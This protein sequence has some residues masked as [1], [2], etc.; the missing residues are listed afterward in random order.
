[1]SR[2][3]IGFLSLRTNIERI[4]VK[5]ASDN[6]Y[7]QRMNWLQRWAKLYQGKFES[8]SN[9][10]CHC[11][12]QYSDIIRCPA[13]RRCADVPFTWNSTAAQLNLNGYL[14]NC[15]F[16]C[17]VVL[18]ESCSMKWVSHWS[19]FYVKQ[20]NFREDMRRKQFSHSYLQWPWPL[21]FCPDTNKKWMKWN[22]NCSVQ[23]LLTSV[24]CP[25]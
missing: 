21:T 6:H 16:S 11:V 24:T 8:T 2:A 13:T 23:L 20:Y 9:R 3:N 1:M 25:I 4:S 19:W 15:A 18:D 7:R 17:Y 5:F 22:E 14:E 12:S 10:W